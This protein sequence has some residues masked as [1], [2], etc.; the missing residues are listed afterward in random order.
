MIDD[1]PRCVPLDIAVL[2]IEP[3]LL[4]RQQIAPILQRY[5]GFVE[6]ARSIEHATVS[7]RRFNFNLCIIDCMEVDAFWRSLAEK[8]RQFVIQ[9]QKHLSSDLDSENVALCSDSASVFRLSGDSLAAVNE[10]A[11]HVPVN[12]TALLYP[13]QFMVMSH[14]GEAEY[15]LRAMRQGASDFI[16]KPIIER[17]VEAAIVRWQWQQSSFVS[18][19]QC[20]GTAKQY[21]MYVG[22]S[23]A[24]QRLRQTLYQVSR[25]GNPLLL[26]GEA[27]TGKKLA[28][29]QLQQLLF[30]PS[31]LLTI[32]CRDDAQLDGNDIT[33][34]CRHS[35]V[36]TLI[37]FA[38][39]GKLSINKQAELLRTLDL[40][41][42]KDNQKI[43]VISLNQASLLNRVT[44]GAFL[45]ELYYRLA[46][47]QVCLPP[48][49]QRSEDIVLLAKFFIN[50]FLSSNDSYRNKMLSSYQL[51][52]ASDYQGLSEYYWPGN[53]Q[54]LK[55]TVE[56]CLLLNILPKE[57]LKSLQHK[58]SQPN[59]EPLQAQEANHGQHY[60]PIEW[61]MKQ[62]EKA[63]TL[64][65]IHR[66]QGNRVLA[67]AHLGVS[68]KT[69]DRKIKEWA[70]ADAY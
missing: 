19:Q 56:Q 3:D 33:A 65:V 64:R 41:E 61:D 26:E 11:A 29:E 21:S 16:A 36:I 47:C 57:Y 63:H 55:N 13:Q 10:Q 22:D 54:E 60:F 58:G 9:Q 67:A 48:L 7:F 5:F 37:V 39:I 62:I 46:A 40:A 34:Y 24:V 15:I 52:S 43:R 1:K 51:W 25:S 6:L 38:N 70:L 14:S 59:N 2:V 12:H 66:Y 28:V 17:H 53:I 32:D 4:I 18:Q 50:R 49:H 42:F 23:I 30:G 44:S 35:K 69:I 27:G 31:Q 20:Q 68:R 45:A 8:N